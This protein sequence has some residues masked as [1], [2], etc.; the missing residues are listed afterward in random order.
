MPSYFA[1]A[2]GLYSVQ[3]AAAAP[4]PVAKPDSITIAAR[5]SSQNEKALIRG[6][7]MSGAPIISG[8]M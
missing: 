8:T 1:W 7:A 5:G 2:S 4:P 3:P 6:K